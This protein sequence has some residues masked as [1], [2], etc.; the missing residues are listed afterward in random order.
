MIVLKNRNS[1]TWIVDQNLTRDPLYRQ[2]GGI[3]RPSNGGEEV[4]VHVLV[5][6]LVGPEP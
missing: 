2:M 3:Q 1:W 4:L 6:T 5:G